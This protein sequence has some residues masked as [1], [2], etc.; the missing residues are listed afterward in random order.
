MAGQIAVAWS[1]HNRVNNGKGQAVVRGGYAGV[2]QKPRQFSCWNKNEPNYEYLSGA[3][4][5]PYCEQ[6]RLGS[7]LARLSTE[8]S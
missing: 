6:E 2:Y 1:I 8:N 4:Q 5:I 3:T 7:L